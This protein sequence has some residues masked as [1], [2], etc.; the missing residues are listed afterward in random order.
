MIAC[1]NHGKTSSAKRNSSWKPKLSERDRHMLKRMVFKS[2]RTAAAKVTAEF[3][4]HLEDPVY[5]ETVQREL[6]KSNIHSRATIA[7]PLS[8]QNNAKRQKR[9]SD[10]RKTW[11]SVD[12][13]YMI[14]SGES[15]MLFPTSGWV[16][17]WKTPKEA[18][19]PEC[20]VPTV[21][22]GGRSVMI[23]AAIYWYSAGP[24]I[25]LNGWI[26]ANDYVDI[27]GN[28][29]HPVVQMLFP[30]NSAVFQDDSSPIH[31]ARSV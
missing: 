21:K 23:W 25:T 3:I 14:W 6:H 1:A 4:V 27:L 29:V 5:T 31:T 18:N 20:M 26:T 9:W 17:V 19:S 7:K 12:W 16:S 15:S 2:H 30:N 28:Q 11:T 13:K 24:I 22:H 8:T 10:G